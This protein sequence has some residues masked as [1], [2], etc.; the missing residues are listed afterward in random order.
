MSEMAAPPS[1]VLAR[2]VGYL[3][4]HG[5]VATARLVLGA[6]GDRVH[7]DEAHA[8]YSLDLGGVGDGAPL[9]EG[10]RLVRATDAELA[11]YVELGEASEAS[12]RERLDAGA[13]LWLV[14]EGSRA[15]FA[16]WTFARETPVAAAR[17]GS[18]RLPDDCVCLED[19]VTAPDFRG[20]GIA[21]AA[22]DAIAKQ[23]REEAFTVMITKVGVENAPSRR[24]VTKAGF[25]EFAIM[26]HQ[27]LA[28][29]RRVEVWPQAGVLGIDLAGALPAR[30]VA[31]APPTA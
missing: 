2:G 6:I 14:T 25:V 24:A 23:L 10:L 27:R 17:G 16:C 15:A 7:L 5:V 8:W 19:S 18:L 28:R 3:R 21:P 4:E 26:R 22:W 20:R 9:P 12:T 29:R 1:G 13:T 11:S 31:S 30:V